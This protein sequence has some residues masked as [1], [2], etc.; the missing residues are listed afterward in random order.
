MNLLKV[1]AYMKSSNRQLTHQTGD[2]EAVR[3]NDFIWVKVDGPRP[4]CIVHVIKIERDRHARLKFWVEWTYHASELPIRTPKQRFREDECILSNHTQVLDSRTF[5]GF[6][7]VVYGVASK[8]SPHIYLARRR[9][10]VRT[11]RLVPL[12]GQRCTRRRKGGRLT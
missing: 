1:I 11:K 10:D 7:C 3:K 5:A 8:V 6:A 12:N 2:A 9:F 4:M